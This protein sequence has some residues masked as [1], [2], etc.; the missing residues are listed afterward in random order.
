MS[1]PTP[2]DYIIRE[3]NTLFFNYIW[4]SK[5]DRDARKCITKDYIDGGLKMINL[6]FFCKSLKITWI[7]RLENSNSAWAILLKSSL[8]HWFPSYH[9]LGNEFIYRLKEHLNL[10]WRQIFTDLC[11]F[12]TICHENILLTP[13][14]C[15]KQISIDNKD[16]FIERWFNKGLTFI[17]DFLDEDNQILSLENLNI[18]FDLA[19]PFVIYLSIVRQI[20]VII[21][22]ENLDRLCRPIIPQY[23][24]IILADLKGCRNIYKCFNACSVD[25][26]NHECKWENVLNL[27]VDRKWWQEHYNIP[28]SVTTDTKL[29]WLQF[30]I[31]HRII[32]TN[33]YLFQ[34]KY[35]DS[36]VCTFCH[37]EK[38]TITHLFWDCIYINPL[39]GE[40][41]AWYN[42]KESENIVLD[43]VDVLF[44]KSNACVTLNMLI[45]LMKNFIYK[46]RVNK[47]IAGFAGFISYLKYYQTIEKDI[48]LKKN[49][50]QKFDILWN[51]CKLV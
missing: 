34:I 45:I 18:K 50:I 16:I 23:L 13:I 29:Q 39:W 21:G 12:R 5:V 11:D 4:N 25:K 47:S 24:N 10:F 3:I 2:E 20:R 31:F 44:G 36:D 8:P 14:W 27:D 7:R 19:M 43:M 6:Q 33:S 17:E 1:L 32:A 49:M 46:Q 37:Y 51:N 42:D 30:R 35:V 15:N 28:F 38:E 9:F 22:T 48:Y 40:F 41:I 26:Y